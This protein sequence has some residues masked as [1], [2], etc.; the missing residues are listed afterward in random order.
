MSWKI[1]IIIIIIK[2]KKGNS[3]FKTRFAHFFTFTEQ[4][5]E[6]RTKWITGRPLNNLKL[7]KWTWATVIIII[8]EQRRSSEFIVLIGGQTF[9]KYSSRNKSLIRGHLGAFQTNQSIEALKI[10][11]SYISICQGANREYSLNKIQIE[12]ELWVYGV[13]WIFVCV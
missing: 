11:V 3:A 7:R 2:T 10:Q 6:F 8:I 9:W 4:T 1:I 13:Q 12:S 5:N